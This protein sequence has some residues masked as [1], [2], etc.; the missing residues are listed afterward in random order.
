MNSVRINHRLI[1]ITDRTLNVVFSRFR[2]FSF[3]KKSSAKKYDIWCPIYELN[4]L[5][6]RYKWLKPSGNKDIEIRKFE[7]VAKTQFL[8]RVSLFIP[9]NNLV[10]QKITTN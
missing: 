7:F 3:T 2:G 4:D 1:K 8:Y 9:K 6:L 5:S 10:V